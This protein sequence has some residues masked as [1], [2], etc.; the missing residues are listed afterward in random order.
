MQARIRGLYRTPDDLCNLRHR[1]LLELV[2]HEHRAPVVI[3]RLE[4]ALEHRARLLLSDDRRLHRV[5]R[6][7]RDLAG[8]L[9]RNMS[10]P[11]M[12]GGAA[13]GDLWLLLFGL[14][15]SIPILLFAS[16]LVAR[17]IHNYPVLNY[18][19]AGVLVITALRMFFHDPVVHDYIDVSAVVQYAIIAGGTAVV[20]GYGY[21]MARRARRELIDSAGT[22]SSE[23]TRAEA[24]QVA[25]N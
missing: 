3:Q 10:A 12:V 8:R 6:L 20:L 14:L 21:W 17:M 5:D 24:D 13:H 1:Q 16:G 11:A 18:I 23:R 7:F 2:E 15:L 19:G 22:H 4:D 9:A 25:T